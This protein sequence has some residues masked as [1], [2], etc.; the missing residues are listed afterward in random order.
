[1]YIKYEFISSMIYLSS[2]DNIKPA[3]IRHTS[4]AYTIQNILKKFK[5]TKYYI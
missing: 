2:N 1:M 4:K 5:T 3:A